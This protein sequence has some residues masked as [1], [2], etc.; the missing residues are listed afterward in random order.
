MQLPKYTTFKYDIIIWDFDGVIL[1]SMPIRDKGF[2]TV[3]SAYPQNE[4]DQ[5]MVYHKQNG[6]LPRYNK[7][8]YFYETIRNEKV[9]ETRINELA[10]EFKKIMLASLRN[11][12]FLI[13]DSVRFIKE[14]YQQYPMYIASGSE[15][16]ELRTICNDL[17]LTHYFKDIKGSPTLKT[18][19]VKQ[20]LQHTNSTNAVLIG[21]SYNDYEAAAA[22]NI[23]FMGY[24]NPSLR[25][26]GE[27][28][29]DSFY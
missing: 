19:L 3:L 18:E 14:N 1:D 20:I 26:V 8:R 9:D 5:L 22:N 7:F 28:Y 25:D 24:N 23:A 12:A 29:I 10:E 16:N 15:Q 13:D 2:E 17:E 21:D 6:G 4:V 11:K 27:N